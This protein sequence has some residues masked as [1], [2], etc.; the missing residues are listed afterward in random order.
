MCKQNLITCYCATNGKMERA[1]KIYVAFIYTDCIPRERIKA[2]EGTHLGFRSNGPYIFTR[3]V[4]SYK[5]HNDNDTSGSFVKVLTVRLG[6][7]SIR[8]KRQTNKNC[9][10]I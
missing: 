8:G 5:I 7:A 4:E 2:G 6:R 1:D 9:L 10:R 3:N